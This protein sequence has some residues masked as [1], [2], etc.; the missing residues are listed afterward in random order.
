VY[1]NFI[2]QLLRIQTGDVG[3]RAVKLAVDLY[4]E[5]QRTNANWGLFLVLA[6]TTEERR[7]SFARHTR[8]LGSALDYFRKSLELDPGG[9]ASAKALNQIARDWL[10]QSAR[11]DDAI[12]LLK[13]AVELHP[14][15]AILY[16]TLGDVYL[17]KGEQAQA[18]KAFQKALE[19]DPGLEH[20]KEMIK[21]LAP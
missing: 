3:V 4:P 10:N 2:G 9:M 8:E 17:K 1:P 14:R 21:K 11:V 15:G 5:H 12:A 7:A 18:I 13:V 16:D 20:A 19:A 6:N